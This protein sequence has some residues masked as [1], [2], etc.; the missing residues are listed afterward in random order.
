MLFHGR[1][2][3]LG[4]VIGYIR[5]P[6]LLFAG[7]TDTALVFVGLLVVL[8]FGILAVSMRSLEINENDVQGSGDCSTGQT[9]YPLERIENCFFFCNGDLRLVGVLSR[10]RVKE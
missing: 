10:E 4:Q 7:S 5:H 8:L 6:R 9:K 2:E 3:L 1:V